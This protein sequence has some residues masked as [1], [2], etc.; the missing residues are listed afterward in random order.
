MQPADNIDPA[1]KIMAFDEKADLGRFISLS[2]LGDKLE[3]LRKSLIASNAPQQRRKLRAR[4]QKAAREAWQAILFARAYECYFGLTDM[5]VR[6]EP[7]E[8]SAH[9]VILRWAAGGD[10]KQIKVQLKELPPLSLNAALSLSQLLVKSIEKY[11]PS[12]DITLAMFIGRTQPAH[13]IEIPKNGFAGLWTFGFTGLG[14]AE[15]I[16]LVGQDDRGVHSNA[17][18]FIGQASR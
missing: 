11:P 15:F 8:Y 6:I 17:K 9:D 18:K 14:K 5:M 12:P 4:D 10:L 13:S 2:E 16:S 1:I 3:A 7:Q